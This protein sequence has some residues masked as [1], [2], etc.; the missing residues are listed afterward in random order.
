MDLQQMQ[1][2][3]AHVAEGNYGAVAQAFNQSPQ[4]AGF[5]IRAEIVDPL[6]PRVILDPVTDAHR[7]GVGSTAVNGAVIAAMFDL[8]IGLLGV[9]F[10]LEGLAATATLNIQY[11]RPALADSVV[12]E[13]ECGEVTARR[14][15][16]TAKL[17][18]PDGTVFA[19][20]QGSLAKGLIRPG[21]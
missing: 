4:L 2:L 14:I 10:W 20:A 1:L 5:G 13:A 3:A 18:G 15:F 9:R 11:L 19:Q 6:R 16:G 21:A 12:V 17:I 8:A 7:G